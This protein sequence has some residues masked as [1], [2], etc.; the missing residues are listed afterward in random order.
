MAGLQSLVERFAGEHP[1]SFQFD[2]Q[3]GYLDHAFASPRLAAQVRGATGWHINADEAAVLDYNTA[4]KTDDP[5][6][7]DDPFRASDPDPLVVGLDL[8][9]EAP[10]CAA[11]EPRRGD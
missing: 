4:F 3:A 6:S 8:A 2:G 11:H 7:I 10:P 9:V 1:Y 5:F